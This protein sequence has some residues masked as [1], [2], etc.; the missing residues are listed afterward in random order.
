[1]KQSEQSSN[2]SQENQ[3]LPP[4]FELPHKLNDS[5]AGKGWTAFAD[6]EEYVD[7]P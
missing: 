5:E 7:E 6:Q 2:R 4:E 3:A 1:M